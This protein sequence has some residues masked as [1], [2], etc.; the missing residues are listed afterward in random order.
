M[1][2]NP[3]P[4][5]YYYYDTNAPERNLEEGAFQLPQLRANPVNTGSESKRKEKMLVV[6]P[7][8]PQSPKSPKSPNR[9]GNERSARTLFNASQMV[10]AGVG[11][12]RSSGN[13]PLSPNRPK[14]RPMPLMPERAQ[15]ALVNDLIDRLRM[16]EMIVLYSGSSMVSV[17]MKDLIKKHIGIFNRHLIEGRERD[18]FQLYYLVRGI[19]IINS[20]KK[21]PEWFYRLVGRLLTQ[22]NTIQEIVSCIINVQRGEGDTALHYAARQGDVE[23]V[24]LLLSLG[25]DR[26][27]S[28][29]ASQTPYDLLENRE[30]REGLESEHLEIIKKLL[31]KNGESGDTD[32]QGRTLLHWAA[33]QGYTVVMEVLLSRE[34]NVE[35]QDE[36]GNTPLHLAARYGHFEAVKL[37]LNKGANCQTR[38]K[39][40]RTVLHQ[41]A[42]GGSLDIVKFLIEEKGM[43]IDSTDAL[44]ATALH[45]AAGKGHFS[46]VKLLIKMEANFSL[47]DM[48][49]WTAYDYAR[50][51]NRQEVENFLSWFIGL[52]EVSWD[53]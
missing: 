15:L 49:G 19:E 11:S 38:N 29:A 43:S 52:S 5:I 13:A 34:A 32:E 10:H 26:S 17:V 8:S 31:K 7:R 48:E 9:R 33:A 46:V 20:G 36:E 3:T 53:L 22:I 12:R 23:L 44:G 16:E 40:G 4:G 45:L 27:I 41:A 21:P 30:I 35:A 14:S 51:R 37:L 1:D 28:N 39:K 18:F 25:A 24:M 47:E 6:P 50:N 42:A 2:H